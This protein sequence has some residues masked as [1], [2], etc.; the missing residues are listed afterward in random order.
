MMRNTHGMRRL[1]FH[2][3]PGDGK[4]TEAAGDGAEGL[5]L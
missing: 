3:L 1:G 4:F 5:F 2:A